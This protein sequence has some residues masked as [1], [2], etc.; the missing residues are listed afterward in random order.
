MNEQ[1]LHLAT[2]H[3]FNEVPHFLDARRSVISIFCGC[4]RGKED[5]A[6]FS[7]LFGLGIECQDGLRVRK[8]IIPSE[9]SDPPGMAIGATAFRMRL[10]TI[11]KR[12]HRHAGSLGDLLA[13]PPLQTSWGTARPW[14]Q[15]RACR[16]QA[17]PGLR[18][19]ARSEPTGPPWK[20]SGT[21]A[22]RTG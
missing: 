15:R 14:P 7:K 2:F 1:Y 13:G 10:V 9:S 8:T 19:R 22:V 17:P 21:C 12:I 20:P 18:S 6:G 11:L 5:A 3:L 4:K 16:S